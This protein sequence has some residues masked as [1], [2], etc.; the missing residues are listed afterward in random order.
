MVLSRGYGGDEQFQLEARVGASGGVVGVGSNRHKEALRLMSEE[1]CD[2]GDGSGP[3]L[4]PTIAIM[5]DGLQHWRMVR[6]LEVVVINAYDPWGGGGLLPSGFL[7]EAPMDGLGRADLVVLHN[8]NERLERKELELLKRTIHRMTRD[9]VRI[10]ETR[11]TLL[12]LHEVGQSCDEGGG[13]GG[14]S[15]SL[16][17]A[18][19]DVLKGERV[20]AISGIG[21]PLSFEHLLI[22]QLEVGELD[23]ATYPDHHAYSTSDV[24]E[25]V[26]RRR[27]SGSSGGRTTVVTTEKDYWRCARGPAV[28]SSL[29]EQLSPTMYVVRTELEIVN[30]DDDGSDGGGSGSGEILLRECLELAK[31]RHASRRAS[32]RRVERSSLSSISP[33]HSSFSPLTAAAASFRGRGHGQVR[34]FH[35]VPVLPAETALFWR[36]PSSFLMGDSPPCLMVDV[37]A[38]GGSHSEVSVDI[39]F[40]FLYRCF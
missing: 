29:L 34:L 39:T 16:T 6:D 3:S 17:R 18:K 4:R 11:P 19:L 26:E 24:V 7:R 20:L 30:V 22:D 21:C 25:L 35:H 2:D 9:D 12:S 1:T 31:K 13:C 37:T 32:E 10:M 40:F 36:P 38:G 28:H 5:D 33:P 14:V 23:M 8:V 27:R 15:P